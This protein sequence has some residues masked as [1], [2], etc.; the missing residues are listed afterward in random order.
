M[1]ILPT[2]KASFKGAYII[3][4]ENSEGITQR[5][6]EKACEHTP[7]AITPLDLENRLKDTPQNTLLHLKLEW[8]YNL[9]NI[10]ICNDNNGDHLTQHKE[11]MK[12]ANRGKQKVSRYDYYQGLIENG[13]KLDAAGFRRLFEKMGTNFHQMPASNLSNH[14]AEELGIMAQRVKR[15]VETAIKTW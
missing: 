14:T 12:L 8:D 9:P 1:R 11:Y 4:P 10:V 7:G 5:D 6:V 15:F 3:D 2:N 13:K